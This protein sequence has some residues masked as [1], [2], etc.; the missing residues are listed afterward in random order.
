MRSHQKQT[1]GQAFRHHFEGPFYR[2]VMMFGIK[3]FS[4]RMQHATMPFWAG[5][6]YVLV[7]RARRAVEANLERVAGPT[8]PIEAKARAFRLFVNY[9]QSITNMYCLHHGQPVPVDAITLGAEHIYKLQAEK[10]G[11]VVVTGHLGFWQIAPILMQ[12]KSYPPLTMAMAEEPNQGTGDWERQFRD[13]F[14]IVY[15]TSSPFSTLGL[16]S[17]L[18]RGEL[19][20]MQMD[21]YVGGPHVWL[22]FCGRPAPFPLGPATLARATGSPLL[23]TFTIADADR[24]RCVFHVE[25]PIEVAHTAD[26]DADVRDATARA[27]AVYERFVRRHPEQ[28]FNFYDFWNPPPPRGRAAATREGSTEGPTGTDA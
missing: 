27:V 28:W 10:R 20:G 5:I 8:T 22:P 9:A 19:V 12:R 3:N 1:A 17:V 4:H 11:A 26:R 14:R 13:K 18:R 25:P 2:R 6:F 23:P 21:R 15:T 24:R 7:P 16:A